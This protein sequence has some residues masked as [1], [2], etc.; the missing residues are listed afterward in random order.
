MSWPF[1]LFEFFS[2]LVA[3][4]VS[5]HLCHSFEDNRVDRFKQ[6]NLRI[7][8]TIFFLFHSLKTVASC[9]FSKLYIC[10]K[11][12]I[13]RPDVIQM[14]MEYQDADG[15]GLTIEEM[16]YQAFVFY[17]ASYD[18]VS[19]ILSFVVHEIALH[20]EIQAKLHREIEEVVAKTDG[21]PTYEALKNMQYM[22]GVI[23]EALRL[24]AVIPFLDRVCVKEFQLPPATPGGQPVTVKP[25]DIVWF[26]SFA[27]QRDSEYFSDPLKFDPDRCLS[28]IESS[29]ATYIPF[30]LGPRLCIGNRFA[31]LMCRVMLFYLFWRCE[32]EPCDKTSIPMKFSTKS[33]VLMAKEGWWL[34]FRARKW[35]LKITRRQTGPIKRENNTR[36]RRLDSTL[37]F[38]MCDRT[39]VANIFLKKVNV[40]ISRPLIG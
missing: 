4:I 26:L 32:L 19:S 3:K 30:G 15:K 33:F 9:L 16:T 5:F 6:L 25:G 22:N 17:T 29:Q 1:H 2:I 23:N 20:P 21:K 38:L 24:Y 7:R 36:E 34:K 10:P 12:G 35:I 18:T 13:Q 39:R 11:Q 8:V 28:P 27:L 40:K 14:M 37:R 31:L